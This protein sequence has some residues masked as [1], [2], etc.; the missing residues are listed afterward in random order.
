VIANA[1]AG[2]T[3]TFSCSGTI[4]LLPGITL[5]KNLTIDSGQSVTTEAVDYSANE[6]IEFISMGRR[7][8]LDAGGT[9]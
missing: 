1:T 2:D 9:H 4:M 3:V 7:E 8:R 5:S 6:V